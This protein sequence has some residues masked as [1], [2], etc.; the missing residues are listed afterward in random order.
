MGSFAVNRRHS[1]YS[2]Y[3][4]LDSNKLNKGKVQKNPTG[5]AHEERTLLVNVVLTTSSNKHL[6]ITR[7]LPLPRIVQG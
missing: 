4:L 1:F 5:S 3:C 7:S 6:M 2:R